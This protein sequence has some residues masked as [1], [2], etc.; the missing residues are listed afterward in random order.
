MTLIIMRKNYFF[1]I[2]MTLGCL[3]SLAQ[4]S[5]LKIEYSVSMKN[6]ENQRFQMQ[7]DL[8]GFKEDTLILKL[9]NWSPGYYQMMHYYQDIENLNATHD[10]G[11]PL[12]IIQLNNN[13]WQLIPESTQTIQ[14]TYK[15]HSSKKFVANSLLDSTHAY[16]V[17]TNNVLYPK[18]Y[19][20]YPSM[21][22]INIQDSPWDDIATGLEPVEGSSNS[23]ISKNFDILYDSPLLIG[24]LQSLT[25][26]QVRGKEHRFIGYQLGKF[27]DQSLMHSLQKIV[28]A[29]VDMFDDIPYD[30]Y[31]FIGIG[32]GRGGI[33]HL[34]S[35]T[36]SFDGNQLKTKQAINGMLNFLSHEYFHHY[37][38]KRIRPFE[39]G[40]FDYD[41]G[42]RTNQLWIAEGLTVY[43]E[44][45]IS[46]KAGI[47]DTE[48]FY[49]DLETHI[50]TVEN[51]PGR[52]FQSL[53]QSSYNTWSDGPFGNMGEEKGKTISYYN[54]GPL[55]G[56]LLDLKIRKVTN[57][58][59][60][61]NDVMYALYHK[62]YKEKGRG[63][64]AAEF[65][66]VCQ[67]LAS[68][69]LDAEFEYVNT[70][71]ELNYNEYLGYAGLTLDT[72][73]T[74]QNQN[75]RKELIIKPLPNPTPEQLTLRNTW[76][77]Q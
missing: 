77:N 20:N 68:T 61:L 76:L 3:I 65:Q 18:G 34:N 48:T 50:N 9:P 19:L 30:Q 43:Y 42:S 47:K 35:T 8:S 66:A 64:T 32:P 21:I 56:L 31:T 7:M 15:V 4:E 67:Q 25:P 13:T 55:V 22:T 73:Q 60:S 17:P 52:H 57:N 74:K 75:K 70:T 39:L 27:D 23:F 29:A 49:N 41:L 58:K 45:I 54:K 36:V 62:F 5:T 69:S 10:N 14:I 6:P 16:I 53:L 63:F 46:K 51:N 26:F 59:A 24:N 1:A 37:N 12:P 11:Q 72:L 28:T 38:A 40:P 33:E 2:F 71:K 44:Y